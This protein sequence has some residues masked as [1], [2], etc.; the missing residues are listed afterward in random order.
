MM[1][2][3][4]VTAVIPKATWSQTTDDCKIDK[5]LTR[6]K[7]LLKT[8]IITVNTVARFNAMAKMLINPCM[9]RFL[10]FVLIL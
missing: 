4:K 1:T 9:M 3:P 5:L 8:G 2:K 6:A 7:R 10:F